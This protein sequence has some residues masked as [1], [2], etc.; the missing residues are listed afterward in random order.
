MAARRRLGDTLLL[1]WIVT[2]SLLLILLGLVV[3]VVFLTDPL[4]NRW[5]EAGKLIGATLFQVGAVTLILELVHLE[6]LLGTKVPEALL[7]HGYLDNLKD[8]RLDELIERAIR[9]RFIG[10]NADDARHGRDWLLQSLSAPSRRD[11]TVTLEL[12]RD[13]PL[14]EP[15]PDADPGPRDGVLCVQ[16]TYEYVTDVNAT[17][18]PVLING[19]GVVQ[20]YRNTVPDNLAFARRFRAGALTEADEREWVEKVA[21]PRIE[22]RPGSATAPVVVPAQIDN[23]VVTS[24]DEGRLLLAFDVR[25]D[26]LVLPGERVKVTYRH[27]EYVDRRGYFPWRA[28]AL[29]HNLRVRTKGFEGFDTYPIPAPSLPSEDDKL[30]VLPDGIYYRGVLY[31]NSTFTF[32]WT[33]RAASGRPATDGR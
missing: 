15:F 12:K 20:A 26:H 31:P 28:T 27:R 14:T 8:E 1:N 9:A 11:Y 3:F 6:R 4:A 21:Q 10:V 33:E 19:N 2:L 7:D 5:S 13:D 23:L 17:A 30:E 24:G 29:T 32:F 22:L 25:C 18:K 16:I